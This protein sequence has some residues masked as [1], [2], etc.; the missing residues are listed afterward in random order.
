MTTLTLT[1]VARNSVAVFVTSRNINRVHSS[2][3]CEVA[4]HPLLEDDEDEDDDEDDE[5]DE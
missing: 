4:V 1:F 5:D 2:A 3:G